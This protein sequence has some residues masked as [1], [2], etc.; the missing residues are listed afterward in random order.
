MF[1]ATIF[2][3]GTAAASAGYLVVRLMLLLYNVVRF[4]IVMSRVF[5]QLLSE[6]HGY[7]LITT[8]GRLTRDDTFPL[9]QAAVVRL[10][11]ILVEITILRGA[12]CI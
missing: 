12:C 10:H 11:C 7:L 3:V 5:L 1:F 6:R 8:T 4:G 9:L 2:A